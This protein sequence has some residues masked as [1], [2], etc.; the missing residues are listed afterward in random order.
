[1][2]R[3][4]KYIPFESKIFHLLRIARGL[5]DIHSTGKVHKDLHS[6]NVLFGKEEDPY[7]SDLGMCQ[8]ANE[9]LS[10]SFV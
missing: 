1:M 10:A 5:L 4:E 3:S 6:G 7:V 2:N 8:L 9:N